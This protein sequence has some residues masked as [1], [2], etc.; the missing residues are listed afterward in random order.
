VVED[1]RA[2]ADGLALAV[3]PSMSTRLVEMACWIET[4]FSR[5][6]ARN[7]TIW[8]TVLPVPAPM[9]SMT[10]SSVY[11]DRYVAQSLSSIAW[12]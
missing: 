6:R 11:T 12:Q 4:T 1:N 7:S 8:S 5:A 9:S 2:V 3:S 10:A